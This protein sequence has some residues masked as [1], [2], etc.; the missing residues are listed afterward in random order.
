MLHF[1][2]VLRNVSYCDDTNTVTASFDDGSF[3]SGNMTVGA[4]GAQSAVRETI[5]GEERANLSSVLY[6]AI[7]LLDKYCLT[8]KAVFVRQ[9]HPN[10]THVIH[11][12]GYWQWIS[13]ASSC[14]ETYYPFLTF[15]SFK[16]SPTGK[17]LQ[18]GPSSYK[19]DGRTRRLKHCANLSS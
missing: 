16:T 9:K 4:D 13:S 10:M 8:E 6:S 19:L 12:D 1:G 7:N 15:R 18:P 3:T 17:M 2:K 14:T 11:Y 5:F